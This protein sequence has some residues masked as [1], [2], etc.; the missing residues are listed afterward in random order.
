MK[1]V[2][3]LE[4]PTKDEI[5][6][7][8]GKENIESNCIANNPTSKSCDVLFENAIEYAKELKENQNEEKERQ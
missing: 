1:A 6:K 4:N 8:L 3:S 7:F 5:I 2:F